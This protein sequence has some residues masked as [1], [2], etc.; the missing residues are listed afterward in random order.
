MSKILNL[1]TKADVRKAYLDVI[2]DDRFKPSLSG[3][4]DSYSFGVIVRADITNIIEKFLSDNPGIYI[5]ESLIVDTVWNY[6]TNLQKEKNRVNVV[7]SIMNTYTDFL[8]SQELTTEEYNI[9][10]S[11][12]T[13][14]VAN[15]LQKI[16][17]TYI[18]DDIIHNTLAKINNYVTL[19]TIDIPSV[20]KSIGD[21]TSIDILRNNVIISFIELLGY[22]YE[23]TIREIS[24]KHI[25]LNIDNIVIENV[26][27][28]LQAALKLQISNDGLVRL[29]DKL[30]EIIGA[31]KSYS[32]ETSEVSLFSISPLS[33]SDGSV[34][35]KE[36][37]PISV[38]VNPVET[39]NLISTTELVVKTTV[40]PVEEIINVSQ[41]DIKAKIIEP[42][43]RVNVSGSN[44]GISI[45]SEDTWKVLTNDGES[46]QWE[47]VQNL[48]GTN[49][50]FLKIVDTLGD[51][52]S[53]PL[54]QRT[55]GMLVYVKSR[56]TYY[57]CDSENDNS[58]IVFKQGDNPHRLS[59]TVIYENVKL[60]H[61]DKGS[62]L[63]IGDVKS[64]VIDTKYE[65]RYLEEFADVENAN[66]ISFKNIGFNQA[67][68]L[69]EGNIHILNPNSVF[70]LPF[71]GTLRFKIKGVFNFVSAFITF[72]SQ[73]EVIK[74]ECCDPIRHKYDMESIFD[75]YF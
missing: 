49:T 2:S 67:E 20:M 72:D 42:K 18:E 12:V 36:V 35:L 59:R 43:F 47:N 38:Q 52:N 63:R 31:Y 34:V 15:E 51:R 28:E 32:G 1:I 41:F 9:K 13:N 39:S 37:T 75:P 64:S 66:L 74:S 4:I 61:G 53:I 48:I 7:N 65:Y 27:I 70:E 46:L 17:L 69:F 23:S 16:D 45:D 24:K 19:G 25:T 73:C 50:G 68:I 30:K 54:K 22:N 62:D 33:L 26:I 11:E 8:K 10:I 40:K 3:I 14:A 21:I 29:R 60:G 44:C 5:S 58:W 6:L 56:D 57:K 55:L 71:D